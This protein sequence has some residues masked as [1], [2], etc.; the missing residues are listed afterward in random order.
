MTFLSAWVQTGMAKALGWTLLHSLWEGAAVALVLAV[1]LGVSQSSR[2]RYWAACGGMLALLAAFGWTFC[3][4]MPR[5]TSDAGSVRVLPPAAV[6]SPDNPPVP[7]SD[8]KW[9]AANLLPWLAPFW[10]VGV[11]LFQLHAVASW[12]AAG[13]MRRMGVYRAS[14]NWVRTLD[15][16]RM[17]L[18]MTRPIVLLE[19]CCA[20]VPVVIGHLRPVIL[21]PMG[22]LAGLPARQ[23]ESIL[24]HELAHIQRADY[25]I[26]LIQILVEGLLFYHPA[27]WWISGTIR[28][29]RENCCD[30]LVVETRGDAHEYASALAALERNRGTIRVTELAVTGGNLKKRIRR[31]LSQSELSRT[32]GAPVLAAGVIVLMGAAA[33]AAW[34]PLRAQE[35]TAP[36]EVV[37]PHTRWL[38]EEAVYII[39]DKERNHFKALHTDAER[40]RFIAQFWEFRGPA[41]RAEHYRRI[42][43]AN[44]R[45]RT[46]RRVGWKTDRGR[47]YIQHGPPDE[48]ESHPSGGKYTR[49]PEQGGGETGTYPFEQWMYRYIDG[50]GKNVIME[51]IDKEGTGE[52][53]MYMDPV[54]KELLQFRR[55]IPE[56]AIKQDFLPMK[57]EVTSR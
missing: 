51:F 48:I 54:E 50:I 16:L 27:M 22:L 18:R 26:N 29:E 8:T 33:L 3:R 1:V 17:R 37:T 52:Y 36:A 31:L 10:L 9:D 42:A 13:R 7:A 28:T 23:M 38:N 12:L 2:V 30:D 19:S 45:F 14:D 11:L 39:T 55:P 40:D 41:F 57:V 49:P 47:I 25:L 24:L 53:R 34:Q 56:A 21:M 44:D 6:P 5:L 32:S 20:E 35:Q 46:K 43:Y 4:L 15:D